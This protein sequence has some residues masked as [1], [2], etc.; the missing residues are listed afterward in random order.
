MEDKRTTGSSTHPP[1]PPPCLG[2]ILWAGGVHLDDPYRDP[3]QERS[4]LAAPWTPGLRT[5]TGREVV[6]V[7]V[8]KDES[9]VSSSSVSA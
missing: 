3:L 5:V 2:D 6:L 8:L 1:P 7:L 4:Y 9:R